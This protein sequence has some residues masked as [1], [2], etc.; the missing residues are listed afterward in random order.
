MLVGGFLFGV[1][2]AVVIVQRQHLQ[3]WY[4]TYQFRT[5]TDPGRKVQAAERLMELQEAGQR[6]LLTLLIQ[7]DETARQAVLRAWQRR[8]KEW[9]GEMIDKW[10]EVASTFWDEADD[11]SQKALL[12]LVLP[13]FERPDA[14]NMLAC[15]KIV[16]WGLR[17]ADAPVRREAV[18]LARHYGSQFRQQWL[19]L[20]KDPDAQVRQAALFTVATL[21]D[22]STWLA[23]EELFHWLHDPD[24]GVR[25]ICQDALLSRGRSVLEIDLGR[26]LT[27]PDANERLKL[28]AELRYDD[29][30]V[31]P[32]PWFHHLV[33]DPEAAVRAAAVRAVAELR[34]QRRSVCPPWVESVVRTDPDSLARRIMQYY[35]E[36]P[37]RMTQ[38][39]LRPAGNPP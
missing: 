2:L 36:L 19:E 39:E 21:A 7:G 34:V 5:A 1:I 25:R 33:R 32:E 35:H 38:G 31:D 14:G 26:R 8:V 22:A 37:L 16:G 6:R 12:G 24:E 4:V 15:R 18:T 20:L 29:V 9:P 3:V 13:V 27:H 11:R 23:D 10:L 28:I 30:V 17:S